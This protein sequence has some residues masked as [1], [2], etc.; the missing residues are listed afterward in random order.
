MPTPRVVGVVLLSLATATRAVQFSAAD[1]A[2]ASHWST[3][4][5][6]TTDRAP[7]ATDVPF[8]FTFGGQSSRTLLATWASTVNQTE[9]EVGVIVRAITWTATEPSSLA[10]T[11]TATIYSSFASAEW[12]LSFVNH[13]SVPTV[14]LGLINAA[15][16]NFQAGS[17][18]FD[19]SFSAGT[20]GGGAPSDYMV[21]TK[22]IGCQPGRNQNPG[23]HIRSIW[24]SFYLGPFISL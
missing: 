2:L 8:S 13:G 1:L 7:N 5:F 9:P 23:A 17:G 12:Q 4:A 24:G 16:V 6:G 10:V 3:A 20:S 21:Q 14:V 11:L 15:D 22:H 19:L 18:P